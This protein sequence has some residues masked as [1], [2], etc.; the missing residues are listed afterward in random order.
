MKRFRKMTNRQGA[1]TVEFAFAAP[2]LLLMIFLSF[3]FARMCL[4]RN[5]AQDAAYEAARFSMVEG[6]T[7]EDATAKATDVMNMIGARGV[8]VVVNDGNPIV[9]GDQTVKVHVS[10]AMEENSLVLPWLYQGRFINA[11]IEL[12]LERYDGFYDASAN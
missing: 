9:R 3:E 7:E 4:I 12:R 11:V 1:T 5:L 8:E 10:V 6:A 2:A